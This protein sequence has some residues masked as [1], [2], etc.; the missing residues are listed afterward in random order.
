MLCVCV[1]YTY[2]QKVWFIAF[3]F[4]GLLS[5]TS[6]THCLGCVTANVS[7]SILFNTCPPVEKCLEILPSSVGNI[8]HIICVGNNSIALPLRAGN[9]ARRT[10]NAADISSTATPPSLWK[11]WLK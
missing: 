2:L 5:L 10:A 11:A 3:L 1:L 7:Y 9:T 8:H 6:V 4:S